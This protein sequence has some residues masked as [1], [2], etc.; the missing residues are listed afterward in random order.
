MNGRKKKA[1]TKS[2][3]GMAAPAAAVLTP[4]HVRYVDVVDICLKNCQGM[5]LERLALPLTV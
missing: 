1:G 3:A 5:A 2:G 4:L